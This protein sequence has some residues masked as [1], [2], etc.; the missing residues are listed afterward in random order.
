MSDAPRTSRG[1]L[2]PLRSRIR[3][4]LAFRV[5]LVLLP[6]LMW[7]LLPST[8]SAPWAPV[9]LTSAAYLGLILVTWPLSRL[10]RR[11]ALSLFLGSLLLDG[12]YL[13]WSFHALNGLDGPMG[14][15]VSLHIVAVTLLVSFRSGLRVTVWHSLLALAVLEAEAAQVFGVT[16]TRAFPVEGFATYL[17]V[18]WITG[19]ATATFA[20]VNERELRRR[21]YDVEVLRRFALSLEETDDPARILALLGEL[22]RDELL[23][24]RV[25]AL[26]HPLDDPGV[27]GGSGTR[28]T[29]VTVTGTE[30]PVFG[31]APDQFPAASLVGR[32]LA[33]REPL[34]TL[35]AD[36]VQDEWLLDLLPGLHHAVVV[37]FVL[38]DQL[39]GAL[40]FEYAR[41]P[42]AGR[43]DRI[44]RRL[45]STAQQATTQAAMALGR[46]ILLGRLRTAAETDGLTEVANRRMFDVT[47]EREAAQSRRTGDSFAVALVD[48]DF[49][50]SLNDEHG[51]LTG[52]DVLR[53]AARAIRETCRE[54]DLA[55]RYGGEEFA[56]IFTHVTADQAGVAA[57]RLRAAVQGLTG[58]VPVTASVG[59]ATF[60]D[61]ADDPR[62]LVSHADAALYLAKSSGRNRVVVAGLG[63]EKPRM[64]PRPR[65]AEPRPA[66]KG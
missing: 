60:P 65:A 13:A 49:F 28:G 19:L 37:P 40:V 20:A 21:R 10:G 12:V 62:E 27:P 43:A 22:A 5:L 48:L 29:V 3:W 63:G 45:L 34:L 8:R 55:A 66:S 52:D 2:V 61:H 46:A 56:V 16:E 26:A 38:E 42:R 7:Q 9:A 47:L 32:A 54:G 1:E 17:G 24:S 35:A 58:S 6:P 64:V 53:Q 50:K 25:V 57:E 59:V 4:T 33:R 51:H 14:Y 23:A 31:E 41:G 30:A 18:L 15:L 11:V 44:E 36:P 39:L